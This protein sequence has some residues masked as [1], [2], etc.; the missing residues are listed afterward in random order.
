V[1]SYWNVDLRKTGAK[2][3]RSGAKSGRFVAKEARYIMVSGREHD[4]AI[5]TQQ[6]R[7]ALAAVG[8][9]VADD[10]PETIPLLPPV[11]RGVLRMARNGRFASIL[12]RRG[13]RPMPP[14]NLAAAAPQFKSPFPIE[15]ETTHWHIAEDPWLG[16][17]R[18][19]DGPRS[20]S[21]T[22]PPTRSLF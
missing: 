5:E 9:I 11:R 21:E 1:A 10:A 16:C 17:K 2:W 6:Q 4:P 18:V 13:W 3:C 20:G 12:R 22:F 14:S 8:S 15:G 7:A 19:D